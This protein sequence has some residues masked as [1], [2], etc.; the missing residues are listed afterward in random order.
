MGILGAW[1]FGGRWDFLVL[2][3][4]KVWGI[5]VILGPGGEGLRV[6]LVVDEVSTGIDVFI[7]ILFLLAQDWTVGGD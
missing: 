7:L 3:Y 6:W 4:P 5:M 2:K 1:V